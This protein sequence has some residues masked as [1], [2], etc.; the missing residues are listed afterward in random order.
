MHIAS[1][2]FA[3]GV[4]VTAIG[5]DV[6]TV[7]NENGSADMLTQ[8]QASQLLVMLGLPQATIVQ[9]IWR[10]IASPGSWVTP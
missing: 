10:A 6:F 7:V 8:L 4:S 1:L 2:P 9:V 5:P 3:T